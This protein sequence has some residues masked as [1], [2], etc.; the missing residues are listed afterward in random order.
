M[1]DKV[2]GVSGHVVPARRGELNVAFTNLIAKI[3]R[4]GVEICPKGGVFLNIGVVK[5]LI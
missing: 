3:C 5:I 2:L 4:L 1:V